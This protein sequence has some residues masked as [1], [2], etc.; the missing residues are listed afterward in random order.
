MVCSP[1][2]NQGMILL[3]VELFNSLFNVIACATVAPVFK[4]IAK[5]HCTATGAATSGR[6]HVTM[7]MFHDDR[8]EICRVT[9]QQLGAFVT[10]CSRLVL[11][12]QNETIG[13]AGEFIAAIAAI[14]LATKE[15]AEAG[16]MDAFTVC[17]HGQTHVILPNEW[18]NSITE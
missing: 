13:V 2:K 7:L 9:T 5:G 18:K 10:L 6:L 4:T 8:R 3:I 11:I 15:Q 14:F 1:W 16:N 12:A 17:Q